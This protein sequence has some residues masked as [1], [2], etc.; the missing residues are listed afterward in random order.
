MGGDATDPMSSGTTYY[1]FANGG[2][3]GIGRKWETAGIVHKGEW[4]V[5]QEGALVVRGDSPDTIELLR[6]LV[7]VMKQIRD[8]RNANVNAVIQ[9]SAPQVKVQDLLNVAYSQVRK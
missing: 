5:P 3:T 2:F 9:T 4:V 6:E 1:G 7:A 8:T